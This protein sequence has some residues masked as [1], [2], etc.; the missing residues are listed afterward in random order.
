MQNRLFAVL[1]KESRWI[2]FLCITV[3]VLDRQCST[4]AQLIV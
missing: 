2:G 1:N 4:I 3:A